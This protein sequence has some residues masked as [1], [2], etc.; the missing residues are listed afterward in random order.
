[1]Q[2]LRCHSIRLIGLHEHAI[3]PVIEIK[4]VHVLRSHEDAQRICDLRKRHIH[5]LRLFAIDGHEHLRVVRRE[6]RNQT[7][8]IFTCASGCDNLVGNAI[9][10]GDRVDACI[11]QHE[12]EAAVTADALHRGR[13]NHSDQTTVRL[14]QECAKLR[15]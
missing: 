13:L 3:G 14:K 12:L 10:I 9:E 6:R 7:G 5:R 15:D 1:M 2:V 8:N 4:V 11:L